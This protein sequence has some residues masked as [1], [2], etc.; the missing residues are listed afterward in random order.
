MCANFS[1]EAGKIG[2]SSR[3][4]RVFL[5]AA[6][7]ATWAWLMVGPLGLA[8]EPELKAGAVFPAKD[9]LSI[10]E[11]K[12]SD[13]AACLD[14]LKWT[15]QSFDVKL[16]KSEQRQGEW[17][18]RFPTPFPSQDPVND[19]VAMEWR[20]AKDANGQP[21]KAPAVVVVHESGRGMV[22]GRFIGGGLRDKG[23]HTFM[24]H[25]PGYGARTSEFTKDVKKMLPALQQAV[26]DVRRARDAAAALPFV[27][28]TAISL[29][30]TSL[31]GFVVATVA[32]L[33]SG[34]QKSFVLLAGGQL[35]DVLLNGKRD[36]A[37]MRKQLEG[38]GVT[39]DQIKTLCARIE[40]MRLAHRIDKN[41]LWLF[42]ANEDEVVPP[43]CTEA[44]AQAI[45]LD[46]DHHKRLP[47]GHY[48]A[49]F[50]VPVVIQ[51]M[52]NV[53]NGRPIDDA[54]PAPVVLPGA[55]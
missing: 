47:A 32:G 40:P 52:A 27:D 16:E 35:S 22:A 55:K 15:P 18:V 2:P 9:T 37:T 25:L 51:Q 23:F 3:N 12:K 53:L 31:G 4:R 28:T 46:A 54:L 49:A 5:T 38:V 21:I 14:G 6:G 41:R 11:E 50:H 7:V 30:G 20:I 24:L 26:G 29:E 1:T 48:T 19:V 13:A 36:A 33:D 43:N 34:Y 17:L 42:S 39:A 44:F 45:G 10:G 8:A